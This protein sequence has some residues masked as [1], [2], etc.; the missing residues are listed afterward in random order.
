MAQRKEYHIMNKNPFQ[1][2]QV[3]ERKNLIIFKKNM[4]TYILALH[5]K[6]TKSIN[7]I[8]NSVH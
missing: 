4:G 8:R 7:Q 5:G 1:L 2:Y 6:D 3:H